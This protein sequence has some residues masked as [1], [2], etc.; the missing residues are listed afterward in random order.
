MRRFRLISFTLFFL[1]VMLAC[2]L[3][4]ATPTP[5]LPTDIIIIPS[6]TEPAP[7]PPTQPAAETALPT[8]TLSP[9]PSWTATLAATISPTAGVITISVTGNLNIRRGP[10]IAYNPVGGLLK[11]QTATASARDANGDWLMIAIPNSTKTGWVSSRTKFSTISGDIMSLPVMT[12]DAA[13]P[14][15]FRNCT[16]HPM[17]VQPVEV[18]IPPQT[19]APDNKIQFNPGD[20][21]IMDASV[22]GEPTVLEATLF[23]GQTVDIRTDGIPNTYSCP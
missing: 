5:I 3:P 10:S 16:F 12:V 22:A 18:V 21:E 15:Y 6:A 19:E 23:E 1:L 20:Y 14:A 4:S 7:V 17:L 8:L 13:K 2:N 9:I 11:G